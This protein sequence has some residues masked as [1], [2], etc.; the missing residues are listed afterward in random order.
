MLT[1]QVRVL[2]AG[3]GFAEKYIWPETIPSPAKR[4]QTTVRLNLQK[5]SLM[6]ASHGCANHPMMLVESMARVTMLNRVLA[7]VSPSG[8][9][10]V[11]SAI[12]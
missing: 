4:S 1:A 7:E 5:R 11:S 10:S 12:A 2:R 8:S 9:P 3:I 6:K